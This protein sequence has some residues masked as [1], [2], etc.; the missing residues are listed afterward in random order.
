IMTKF[1]KLDKTKLTN[2]DHFNFMEEFKIS[3]SNVDISDNVKLSAAVSQFNDSFIEE[4]NYFMLSRANQFTDIINQVDS[5]RDNA[6]SAIRNIVNAWV[7]CFIMPDE[8]AAAQKV[9]NIIDIYNLDINK[10]SSTQTAQLT[11]LISDLQVETMTSSITLLKLNEL[12][13][14][15]SDK[16]EE[17]KALILQRNAINAQKQSGALRNARNNVDSKYD[18]V[19]Q[20]IEAYSVVLENPEGYDNFI[21]AWNVNVERY[22]RILNKSSY[23]SSADTDEEETEEDNTNTNGGNNN[24]G[25]GGTSQNGNNTNPD[26]NGIVELVP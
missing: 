5:E 15:L 25:N 21:N 16:N 10:R 13:D 1:L 19:T 7:N 8:Q 11:N 26:Q 12:L 14:F 9:K 20:I 3:L 17:F 4:D 23:N 2:A 6:Y 18:I 24:N 22:R